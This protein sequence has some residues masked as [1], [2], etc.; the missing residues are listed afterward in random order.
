VEVGLE[1]CCNQFDGFWDCFEG[2]H[3]IEKLVLGE[4]VLCEAT[5]SICRWVTINNA[6]AG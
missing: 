3:E 5:N 1:L 2:Y 4:V 6:S